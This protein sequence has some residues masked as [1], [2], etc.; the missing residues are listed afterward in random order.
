MQN[1]NSLWSLCKESSSDTVAP[2]DLMIWLFS[3]IFLCCMAMNSFYP[4]HPLTHTFA[5]KLGPVM[6]S[7]TLQTI[8]TLPVPPSLSGLSVPKLSTPQVLSSSTDP[9]SQ[10]LR[11][12]S[13]QRLLSGM[14]ILFEGNFMTKGPAQPVGR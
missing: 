4:S 8:L 14:F 5:K 11:L 2:S 3:R 13:L 7:A 9:F 1:K 10:N 6:P 12:A